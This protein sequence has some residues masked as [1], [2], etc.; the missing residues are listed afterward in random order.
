MMKPVNGRYEKL[1]KLGLPLNNGER[2]QHPW[3]AP[4]ESYMVY[5][6]PKPGQPAGGSLFYAG[7][8]A[9]G[10]WSEP[11]EIELGISAGQPFV[12]SDGKY[13]FFT[14][15]GRGQPGE[16]D[17]YWVSTQVMSDLKSTK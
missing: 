10:T 9:N 14:S 3:I 17:I 5:T 2:S 1:E 7:R 6:V 16:G 15:G 11:K 13:L 8:K 4:D 12:T